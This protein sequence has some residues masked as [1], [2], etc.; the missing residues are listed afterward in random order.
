MAENKTNAT[1]SSVDKFINSV[2]NKNT[3]TDCNII[4]NLMKSVTKEDPVMWGPSIIGFGSYHYK[5]ESGKEGDM[6]I[7]GFSP[8]KQNLTVYLLPG[9]EKQTENLKK[10]RKYKTGKACLYFKSLNDIDVKILKKMI[11]HSVMKQKNVCKTK[12]VKLNNLNCYNFQF[13]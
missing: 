10:L 7:A 1:K 2:K 4:I 5:Y 12:I 6:C 11:T 9:F 8:R 13:Y 3:C